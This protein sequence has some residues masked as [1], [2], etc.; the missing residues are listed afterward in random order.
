MA[1]LAFS[2]TRANAQKPKEP[3]L[4]LHRQKMITLQVDK[5]EIN[6]V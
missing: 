6:N 3:F 1:H 4:P 5:T 2:D